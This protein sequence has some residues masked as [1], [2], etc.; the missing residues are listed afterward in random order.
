[1]AVLGPVEVHRDELRVGLPTG[2]TT[3][4]LV[5]LAL[6]AGR[7]VS[8]DRLIEDV[9]ADAVN[10]GRNTLQSKVSQLRK[11]LQDPE[12]LRGGRGGYALDV[13]PTSVDALRAAG[14]AASAA[15]ARRTGDATTAVALAAEGLA[16]FRGEV[17]VDVGDSDWLQAQRAQLEE[18]RMGLLE[19][20]FAAR[21]DL[22]AGGEVVGELEGLTERYP[23]REGL[24]SSLV[25]ALYRAGRQAEALAAYSRVRTLL[26]DELGVEPGPTLQVLET[27]ILRQSPALHAY[28]TGSAAE[29]DLASTPNNLPSLSSPLVGRAADLATLAL[30]T[31]DHRLVTLA[32]P[33]G[34]G[35]TRLA[36]DVVRSR[37]APGGV[38]LVRLDAADSTTSLARLAAETLHLPG[39]EQSLV[40]R[41]AGAETVLVLDGCE[42]VVDAVAAL[43]GALLDE[44]PHLHVIATSQVP[45]GLDGEVV[46]QIEPLTATDAVELFEARAVATR[47]RFAL[48]ADTTPIVHDVCVALDGLPLAIELAAARTR[49]LSVHEISRRLDDRFTLL[50]DPTSRRP[51]R[52]RALAAAIAWSYDL[53][54]PDDQRGLWA[55]SYF[56]G[57]APLEA[58]EVVLARLDVPETSAVDVVSRLVAR[59]LAYLEVS[60]DGS[61][62]YRL[63]DS[64]RAYAL[65]RL[66]ES[67]L[68]DTAAAAHAMW[69][70]TLADRCAA[71]VRG[72]GQAEA[73]ATVR[74]ER[75][76]IDVALT[77]AAAHDPLLGGRIAM[78]FGWTWVVLGDGVAG[79]ERLRSALAAADTLPRQTRAAGLLVAGWLEASAGNLARAQA[80]LDEALQIAD[81]LADTRLRADADRHRAFL[82]IQLGRPADVMD[83]ASSSITASRALRLSWETAAALVLRAYGSIMVGDTAHAGQDAD[84][85]IHLLDPLEDSWGLVHAEAMLGAIAQAEHR[86]GDAAEHLAR[87]AAQSELLGFVG[88]A[89][90]HLASLGR[91]QQRAGDPHA[92]ILTLNRAILA[93]TDSGDLRLAATARLH[94]ARLRRTTGEADAA[95]SLLEQNDRWYQAAGGGEGA[96]LTRCLLAAVDAQNGT[97]ERSQQLL[98]ILEEGR[99][100]GDPE[101]QVHATDALARLADQRGELTLARDLLR[102]ADEIAVAAPHVVDSRDRV[103]ADH[104]RAALGL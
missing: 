3:E 65:D 38:W 4:V 12:L 82:S 80:D 102:A 17:L 8:V 58:T 9:W 14:L 7:V 77:W 5:R 49:S 2:K 54:F 85:A 29:E 84:E 71:T 31:R 11:A 67:G 93:A 18:V 19:D 56:S 87:A 45:L 91:V 76:N 96:L 32:G 10:T 92:A 62:R 35:K 59:S 36:I 88:Q 47:S 44:A 74:A 63:L 15:A 100:V 57:G 61:V 72:S 103:D 22:G 83:L 66:R 73:V 48:D 70:A 78:G 53:L 75:A 6:D 51:E 42:H 46:H 25:T 68:H 26:V 28:P 90:L 99:R 98:D 64:I 41:L 97:G 13:D 94:L 23:L 30:L 1:M 79:A 69:Y 60:P 95:R 52:R 89:A 101:V 81:E 37:Q 40:E 43:V 27:Q 86:F 33:A 20:L 55:L 50:R 39:G 16:L 24:W 21:V 104:T 34:V